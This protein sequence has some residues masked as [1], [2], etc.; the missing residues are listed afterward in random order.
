MA[1]LS[2]IVSGN[3]TRIGNMRTD[4]SYPSEDTA[5]R[6]TPKRTWVY[7]ILLIFVLWLFL[8]NHVI[9]V[10][11]DLSLVILEKTSWTLNSGF[12]GESSWATFSLHHP[13]LMTRLASG[14]GLWILGELP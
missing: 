12:I 7:G 6:K 3:S 10:T 1:L 13:I 4:E 8:A 2:W 5:K 11:D 14:D 9:V